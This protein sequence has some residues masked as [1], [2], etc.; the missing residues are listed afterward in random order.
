MTTQNKTIQKNMHASLPTESEHF[1]ARYPLWMGA[2]PL[3]IGLFS[4]FTTLR[5]MLSNGMFSAGLVASVILI[6]LGSLFLTR[7]YFGIAPN[8]LTV[9]S[10]IGKA[11]KRYPFAS[12]SDMNVINGKL[13]IESNDADR[14]GA[15]K[16]KVA[17]RFTNAKD[18]TTMEGFISKHHR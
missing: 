6:I 17:K 11:I 5:M 16:V 12:F 1:K 4:T 10:L 18:W 7:P 3:G 13:Y 2:I 15:E 8:R 9:Y 14:T